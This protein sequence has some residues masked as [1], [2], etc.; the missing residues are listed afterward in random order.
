[1]THDI[2]NMDLWEAGMKGIMKVR[3]QDIPAKHKC[4]HEGYEYYKRELVPV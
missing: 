2:K 4:E 3:L 1:M